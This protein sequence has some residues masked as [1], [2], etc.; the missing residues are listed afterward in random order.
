M[1]IIVWVTVV[2]AV[3]WSGYWF[4]GARAMRGAADMWLQARVAEGW[5]VDTTDIDVAGFP[6]R[7]D[8]TFRDVTVFDP[9]SGLGWT[10]AFFKVLMLSYKP[11][12]AIL[13]FPERHSFTVDGQ[14]LTVESDRMRGSIVLG[15][16]AD[17]PLERSRVIVDGLT[18]RGANWVLR[19]D[20]LRLASTRLAD[21][22]TALQIGLA[23]DALTLPA[24]LRALIDPGARLPASLR[25]SRLDAIVEFDRRWDRFAIGATRPRATGINLRRL[26]LGWGTLGINLSGEMT[27]SRTGLLSGDLSLDLENWQDFIDLLDASGRVSAENL[28]LLTRAVQTVALLSGS[29]ASVTLPITVTDGAVSVAMFP[30]GRIG[31]VPGYL[32]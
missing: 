14:I 25:L 28:V 13:I 23:A 10:G 9:G 21:H 32:Q 4:I 20:Q 29:G 27:V 8:T 7:F 2:L 16:S 19:A 18:L 12:H 26:E 15:L 22:D 5:R 3:L 17:A 11:N 24:A 30:V 31:P 6:N 1:R